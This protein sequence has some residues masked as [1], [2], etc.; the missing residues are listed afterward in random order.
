MTKIAAN[1]KPYV[2]L[3]LGKSVKGSNAFTGITMTLD[4]KKALTGGL[5]KTYSIDIGVPASVSFGIVGRTDGQ[6]TSIDDFRGQSYGLTGGMGVGFE[7]GKSRWNI[8]Q[9]GNCYFAIHLGRN[10]YVVDRAYTRIK[11]KKELTDDS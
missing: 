10:K 6:K 11:K 2:Y 5:D 4:G 9:H 7:G 8:F 1:T 3:K